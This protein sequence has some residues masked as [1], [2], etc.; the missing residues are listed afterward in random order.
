MSR[1]CWGAECKCCLSVPC[2]CKEVDR[3]YVDKQIKRSEVRT[4]LRQE[5]REEPVHEGVSGCDRPCGI[6]GQGGNPERGG[7]D[8]KQGK[9][10]PTVHSDPK[11]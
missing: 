9:D 2:A 7:Y 5:V 11:D 6:Q 1:I 10:D 3:K 8:P 4:E